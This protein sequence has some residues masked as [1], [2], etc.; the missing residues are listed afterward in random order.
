MKIFLSMH[1]QRQEAKDV[2]SFT[3]VRNKKKINVFRNTKRRAGNEPAVYVKTL[4]LH[5]L[6]NVFTISTEEACLS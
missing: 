3:S 1:G 2:P 4:L 5:V 6:I